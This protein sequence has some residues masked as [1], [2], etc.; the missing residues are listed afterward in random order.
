[1][2]TTILVVVKKGANH[3]ADADR[4]CAFALSSAQ[5]KTRLTGH[6][7]CIPGCTSGL[8]ATR[9]HHCG[10]LQLA[11]LLLLP[12]AVLLEQLLLEELLLLRL[13][14]HTRTETHDH[15]HARAPTPTSTRQRGAAPRR[16]VRSRHHQH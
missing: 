10:N 4:H 5:A 9:S 12:Q 3:G 7:N 11:L 6:Q 2:F 1:L 16:R 13:S 14:P 8:W 15:K